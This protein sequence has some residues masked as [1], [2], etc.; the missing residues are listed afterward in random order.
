MKKLTTLLGAVMAKE[1]VKH[2]FQKQIF[3]EVVLK[4]GN[5]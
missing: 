3:Y 1:V 4:F 5:I 2:E